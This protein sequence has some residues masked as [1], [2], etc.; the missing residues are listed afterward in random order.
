MLVACVNCSNKP[1]IP[2]KKPASVKILQ[3]ITLLFIINKSGIIIFD[4][5]DF[6]IK[7]WQNV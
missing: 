2:V 7:K 3:W 6:Y 4:G 5:L 1:N